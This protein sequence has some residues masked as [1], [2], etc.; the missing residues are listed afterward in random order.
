MKKFAMMFAV[1]VLVLGSFGVAAA[2]GDNA[3]NDF[4]V[5]VNWDGT[6]LNVEP[7]VVPLNQP[8]RFVA[9]F[10]G[11]GNSNQGNA[12]DFAGYHL[13]IW[14]MNGDS[15]T[16]GTV[17]QFNG[18][19]AVFRS[20]SDNMTVTFTEAGNYELALYA[21]NQFN[22]SDQ[23][24]ANQY[25]IANAEATASFTVSESASTTTAQ[26]QN[27]QSSTQAQN[28][29]DQNTQGQSTQSDQNQTAQAQDQGPQNL[30]TTGG[31]NAPWLAVV[32]ALG[33]LLLIGG[34]ALLVARP[35]R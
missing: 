7:N 15:M 2:Q 31:E 35:N 22:Q 24:N 32:L 21:A 18:A 17:W 19:P 20:A 4:Q 1:F 23:N 34:G 9:N 25:T 28:N 5:T 6:N 13:V 10:Q 14:Q 30:P 16:D 8:V 27:N 26:N 12:S 3:Q 11:Q 33:A 29:Q